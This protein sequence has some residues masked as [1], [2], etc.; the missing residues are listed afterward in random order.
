MASDEE[1]LDG[2]FKKAAT[3]AKTSI[4]EIERAAGRDFT[5]DELTLI[6]K[7]LSTDIRTQLEILQSLRSKIKPG[8][9]PS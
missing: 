5:S 1:I 8:V 7:K 3:A 6:L 9:E 4:S 2:L